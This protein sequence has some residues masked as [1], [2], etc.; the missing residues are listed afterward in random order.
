M[1]ALPG[2]AERFYELYGDQYLPRT[3]SAKSRVEQA[4]PR[5]VKH[6]PQKGSAVLDLCCGG[7][8]YAFALEDAGFRVTGLDIQQKMI[9]AARK[10]AKRK[11]SRA[12]FVKGDA[13]DPRFPDCKFGA[14]VFLGA[15]FGHFSLD[16]YQ[17]IASQMRRILKPGGISITEVHDHFGLFFS[18]LYQRITYE[19]SADRDI[20]SIHTRYDAQEGTFNRLY[21]DLETNER[22]KASNHI[23]AP[24]MVNYLMQKAGFIRLASEP[25]SFGVHSTILVYRKP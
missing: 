1:Q 19:P 25:G 15:S 9:A 22:F 16:E 17:T 14:V 21:L 13:I 2:W 6:L 24:W 12:V 10:E 8:A 4:L 3:D 23:W 5:I 7:G 11:G 20:V 18:G